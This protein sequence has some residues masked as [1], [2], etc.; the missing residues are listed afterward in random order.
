MQL[1]VGEHPAQPS[2]K[3]ARE[4]SSG[5]AKRDVRR[6]NKGGDRGGDPVKLTRRRHPSPK[7]RGTTIINDAVVVSI[8]SQVVQEVSGAEPQVDIGRGGGSIPGDNSPTMGK[9]FGRVTGSSRGTREVSAEVSETQA[10]VNLTTT[11]PYGRSIP[12]IIRRMRDGTRT[13][14]SPLLLPGISL[15]F[16]S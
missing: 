15:S 7:R 16:S 2:S 9:L 4:P 3:R 6:Q 1:N 5:C 8:A 11:V 13:R 14:G 10:A 12:E